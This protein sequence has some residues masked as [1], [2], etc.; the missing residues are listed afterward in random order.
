MADEEDGDAEDGDT[1]DLAGVV[2]HGD[3]DHVVGSY[4]PDVALDGD[5]DEEEE[6]EPPKGGLPVCIGAT[7]QLGLPRGGAD[8]VS[9]SS[10]SSSS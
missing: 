9:S 6:E 1:M 3:G 2:F 10:S 4:R 7:K 5:D 8:M